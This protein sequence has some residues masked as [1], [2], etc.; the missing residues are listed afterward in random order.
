MADEVTINS[1]THP[2]SE[3]PNYILNPNRFGENGNLSKNVM[4]FSSPRGRDLVGR[5]DKFLQ[6]V[7]ARGDAGLFQFGLH[8]GR[9]PTTNVVGKNNFGRRLEGLN[10]TSVDYLGLSIDP[11]L[12]EASVEAARK[13]G[14]HS[15]SVGGLMGNYPLTEELEDT[16]CDWLGYGHSL[17]FP[18][19]WAASFGAIV[20]LVRPHDFVVMD[21]LAHAS[22]QQGSYAATANVI[23]FKH[24]SS[25][26]AAEKISAVRHQHPDS[27]ILVVTE[28]MYSMDGDV[29]DLDA[30]HQICRLNDAFLMVDIC[31]D[32][33]ASGP[34]GTGTIG[35]QGL[36]GKVD[37]VVGAFSK[38]LGTNGGFMLTNHEGVI[39]SVKFFGG[40][41]TYSTAMTP[42]QIAVALKAIDIA[43]SA[44]GDVLRQNLSAC[45][46]RMRSSLARDGAVV[47][48]LGDSHIVP[49]HLGR[50]GFAR[51]AGG[52]AFELGVIA[53]V[54]EFP[55]VALGSARYRFS[56]RPD[57]TN[58]QIDLA[59]SLTK[60]AVADAKSWNSAPKGD[61]PA[62]IA[63][64]AS[65]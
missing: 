58:E 13:Y 52:R 2:Y 28:G 49:L 33:A 37:I 15:V 3:L 63:G 51:I 40:S 46:D 45:S 25:D 12:T 48:G 61:A 14:V 53:T 20:G 44:E 24:L 4:R 64:E 7:N 21:E 9:Q 29:P 22:L 31:H 47:Y 19:G 38:A 16:L 50:E 57:Y 6:W 36:L 56:M 11:R 60:Q 55:V 8:W 26:D 1:A 27:A 35:Q 59:A 23:K 42:P 41:Y 18:T 10:F 32:L 54:I 39:Y 17:L 65:L 62:M 43:R 30:L 5:H 34:H